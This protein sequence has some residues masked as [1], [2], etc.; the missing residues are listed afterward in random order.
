VLPEQVFERMMEVL[1]NPMI[2]KESTLKAWIDPHQ[3]KRHQ[4]IWYKDQQTVVT[5]DIKEK[6]KVIHTYHNSLVYGH[7]GISKT[8]QLT[9]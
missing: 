4:G 3:L 9:K 2:Q 5:G 1:P 6:C 7:P 8:V